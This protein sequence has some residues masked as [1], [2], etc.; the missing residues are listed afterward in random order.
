MRDADGKQSL[1]IGKKEDA[2]DQAGLTEPP[3]RP[4]VSGSSCTTFKSTKA[5][6]NTAKSE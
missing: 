4:Q 3:N 2:F 5:P 1:V 6:I